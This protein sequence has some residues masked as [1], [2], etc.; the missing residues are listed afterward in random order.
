[1]VLNTIT[2]WFLDNVDQLVAASNF[3]IAFFM[4]IL[5]TY[6]VSYLIKI[7]FQT[8]TDLKYML[9]GLAIEAYGWFV[10]RV[11]WGFWRI[12]KLENDTA[13]EKW[14]VDNAYIA[15][16]PSV[17][18]MLG[19]AMILGPLYNHIIQAKSKL[20]SYL[21]AMMFAL[22]VFWFVFFSLNSSYNTGRINKLIPPLSIELSKISDK[23]K[24]NK[25]Y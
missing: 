11:Y 22:S 16:I 7:R 25:E 1:M 13:T 19:L 4:F 8:K 23:N 6:I 5:G 2:Q 17:M 9:S 24:I 10:H 12:A 18:I 3:A 14:Y 20:V 21:V 15:V